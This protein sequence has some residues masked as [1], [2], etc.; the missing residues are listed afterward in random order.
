[1]EWSVFEQ[2]DRDGDGSLS[3]GEFYDALESFGYAAAAETLLKE[4]DLNSD[5]IISFDEFVAGYS[6][7]MGRSSSSQRQGEDRK[8]FRGL[9]RAVSNRLQLMGVTEEVVFAV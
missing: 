4:M 1:M 9:S 6:K 2:I 7:F 8:L 3:A 5:G